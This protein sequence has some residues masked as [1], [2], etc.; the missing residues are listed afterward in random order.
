MFELKEDAKK[1]ELSD[2][3]VDFY[4]FIQD[5]LRC[6][7]FDSSECGPPEPMVNAMLGLQLLKENNHRLIMM[8]HKAPGGLFP[9]I[10]NDF[11]Y[12]IF[13]LEDGRAQIV[14][15]LKNQSPSKTDFSANT[16]AG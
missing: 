9:R 12:E 11:S 4:E 14:F 5:G 15:S 7:Y 1:I 3:S 6:Y 8:N 10:Q 16:C 13:D 2:A